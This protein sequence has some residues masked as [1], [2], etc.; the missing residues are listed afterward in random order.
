[1]EAELI[2]GVPDPGAAPKAAAQAKLRP[3]P[4]NRKPPEA[5]RPVKAAVETAASYFGAKAFAKV[6]APAK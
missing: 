2:V 3:K 4:S 5:E 6:V 1:L